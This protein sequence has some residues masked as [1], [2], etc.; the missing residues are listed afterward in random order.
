MMST[1]WCLMKQVI[2]NII[3]IDSLLSMGFAKS[4]DSIL[5]YIPKE[6]K[7]AL[8][9][10]TQ[11][12][13]VKELIRTGLQ[14]PINIKIESKSLKENLTQYYHVMNYKDK[15][16]FLIQFIID[17]KDEKILIFSQFTN[18]VKF[19]NEILNTAVKKYE[20][21]TVI[22]MFYGKMK[23]NRRDQ[24]LEKMM[25]S[26]SGVMVTTDILARGID[27]KGLT[28]VIQFDFNPSYDWIHRSG[29][30]ARC[31]NLGNNLTMLTSK[32]QYDI[33]VNSFNNIEFKKY[34]PK[35][36]FK[37]YLRECKDNFEEKL[38]TVPIKEQF[39]ST[40][41]NGFDPKVKELYRT[42][43]KKFIH[44]LDLNKLCNE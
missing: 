12:S 13:N 28:Y 22:S 29:R 38:F 33:M 20:I 21:P 24:E 31:G 14:K 32:E 23:Q 9:S 7:T 10:A 35:N 39:Y 18:C 41:I 42:D 30:T 8:F 4:I 5:K 16:N 26:K 37:N 44:S 6:R 34:T 17:H 15:L 1:Y 25:K 2:S 19:I 36:D 40:Y 11:T 27:I 3:I 43:K